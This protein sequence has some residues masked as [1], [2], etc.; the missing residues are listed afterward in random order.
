FTIVADLLKLLIFS[1][2]V[3]LCSTGDVVNQTIHGGVSGMITGVDRRQYYSDIPDVLKA[4]VNLLEERIKEK[5]S[6]IKDLLIILK[7][8]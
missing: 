2:S 6:Q 4:H 1:I 5:D 8:K 7:G 3:F